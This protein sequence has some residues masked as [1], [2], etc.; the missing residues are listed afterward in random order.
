MTNQSDTWQH[1]PFQCDVFTLTKLYAPTLKKFG[2]RSFSVF[3]SRREVPDLRDWD[4]ISA[5]AQTY[6]KIMM[7]VGVRAVVLCFIAVSCC[8]V[9]EC[10]G[11][12]VRTDAFNHS[13]V[14]SA[15]NH[16][17]FGKTIRRNV[18]EK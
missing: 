13:L 5:P 7:A 18:K 12:C 4:K 2:K 17:S 3:Q 9:A 1:S 10:E 6:R 8:S 15:K 14:D 11:M 16:L